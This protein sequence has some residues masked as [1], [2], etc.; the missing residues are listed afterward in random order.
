MLISTLLFISLAIV[1]IADSVAILTLHFDSSAICSGGGCNAVLT[2]TYAQFLG[3]P[4]SIFGLSYYLV[5]LILA[6]RFWKSKVKSH[7]DW[8]FNLS[9]IGVLVSLYLTF[10]QGVI[11]NQWCPYCLLSASVSFSIFA[12]SFWSKRKQSHPLFSFPNLKSESAILSIVFIT[13]LCGY[14]GVH[15]YQG[16][17]SKVESSYAKRIATIDGTPITLRDIDKDM[18]LAFTKK[19]IDI[20]R[21]R[22]VILEKKLLAAEA[23]KRGISMAQLSQDVLEKEIN[24]ISQDDIKAYYNANK[25]RFSGKSLNELKPDIKS[26]LA[27]NRTREI[28]KTFISKMKTE[29]HFENFL[30]KDFYLTIN[31]NSVLKT[32]IGPENATLIITLFFDYECSHCK[33]AY[34]KSVAL[35]EKHPKDIQIVFKH[36]PIPTHKGAT[37]KAKASVCAQEQGQFLEYSTVLFETMRP[38][39]NTNLVKLSTELGLDTGLFKQCIDSKR[40]TD[41]LAAD[42]SEIKRLALTG[43]PSIFFNGEYMMGFPNARVLDTLLKGLAIIE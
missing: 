39:S 17:H 38:L 41:I 11:I 8:I 23:K 15:Y 32:S 29:H 30:P 24:A 35:Q 36:M 2:S 34:Y 26:A 3:I 19:K 28:I 22:L 40:T 31:D 25:A 16:S 33:K 27:Y 12:L 1:G 14:F 21:H 9:T 13:V 18:D 5:I 43:T 4:V 7:I 20:Y 37:A 42:L 10:I 6:L